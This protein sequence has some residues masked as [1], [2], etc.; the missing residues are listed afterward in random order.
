M[1]TEERYDSLFSRLPEPAL[2][3]GLLQMTVCLIREEAARRANRRQ[4]VAL[5]AVTAAA[6]SGIAHFGWTAARD[7]YLSGF[8][9]V[10]YLAVS[11]PSAIA[12]SGLSLLISLA[13]AVPVFSLAMAAAVVFAYLEAVRAVGRRFVSPTA[14]GRPA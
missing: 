4:A 3:P 7:L 14:C 6:L 2:P 9:D 5:A 13:E 8:F 10:A 11:E 12:E 1:E